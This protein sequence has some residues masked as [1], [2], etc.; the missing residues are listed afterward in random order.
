MADQIAGKVPRIRFKA[1]SESWADEKIGDVLAEKRRPIV[2]EDDQRYELITVKRRNEGVVSRGHLNGRDILVK[3]YAQLKAGDFVISKRQVVHGAT[4]IVPPALDGAIVSNEY[5]TAVDS[6]KLLTEFLTIVASL[7]AMRKQFFLSSYGVDIEKLFFDADDWKKR[8]VTLPDVQEQS[9]ISQLFRDVEQLI[10]LHQRKHEKLVALKMA[11]LEKMFPKSGTAVP[12]VRFKGF[13]GAW[14]KKKLGELM[15]ITSAARVHKHEWTSSG[16]PFFRTSD[17]VAR[18]NGEQNSKAFISLEL[19][20]ELSKRVGR[21]KQGD[22]LI[23]GGGSIGV[24]FLVTSDEPLYFKDADLLW[25]KVPAGID[26][27]YLYSYFCSGVFS[28]YLESISHIGTIGHYT[29][30]QAKS[31]PID[32]PG[33]DEQQKLGSYFNSLAELITKHAVLLQKLRQIKSAFL[34]DMFAQEPRP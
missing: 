12:E 10:S 25:L 30:E 8:S 17:V 26:S 19:F 13:S 29:I 33:I 31:T 32:I 2:L 1:Y 28:K 21:I 18:Y 6:E 7:P 34:K 5:L 20:Q 27:K 22:I 11:M 24:P 23:T 15:P 14:E 4:G 16:V 3:N 9:L